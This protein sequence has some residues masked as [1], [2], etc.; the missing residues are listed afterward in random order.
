VLADRT[1]EILSRLIHV[2][3]TIPS[4]DADAREIIQIVDCVEISR[5][6]LFHVKLH[7]R[8]GRVKRE[9]GESPWESSGMY[10]DFR[11]SSPN[12]PVIIQ[13]PPSSGRAK[14][15]NPFPLAAAFFRGVE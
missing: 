11:G 7:M 14:R 1:L 6:L 5:D 4:W 15:G 8:M 10:G 3:D 2:M 12:I 9:S 13:Q